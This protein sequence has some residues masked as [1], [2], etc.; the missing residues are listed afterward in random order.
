MTAPFRSH[1]DEIDHLLGNDRSYVETVHANFYRQEAGAHVRR[2]LGALLLCRGSAIPAR[3]IAYLAA[4]FDAIA[5]GRA[6]VVGAT[7]HANPCDCSPEHPTV[8]D[9]RCTTKGT[10]D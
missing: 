1:A 6:L 8:R 5:S 2:M 9:A 4:E 10:V 7:V 3:D